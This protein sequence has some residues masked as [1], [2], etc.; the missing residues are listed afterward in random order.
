[1]DDGAKKANISR[2]H[3]FPSKIN[4]WNYAWKLQSGYYSL[5]TKAKCGWETKFSNEFNTVCGVQFSFMV[6]AKEWKLLTRHFPAV[7]FINF[8]YKV[9]LTQ[10]F[11]SVGNEWKPSTEPQASQFRF[12]VLMWL[13]TTYVAQGECIV[14]S[15]PYTCPFKWK[16]LFSAF[17]YR[18][19]FITT[20]E[21]FFLLF[22]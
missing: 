13:F 15:N 12:I 1:M 6:W 11:K 10:S 8:F 17:L 3:F 14:V 9:T 5:N 16:L 19:L 18:C 20:W 7:P 2:C 22:P 4:H 21:N